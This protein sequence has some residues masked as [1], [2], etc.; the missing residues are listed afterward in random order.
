MKTL[1]SLIKVIENPLEIYKYDKVILNDSMLNKEG[2][3]YLY[4]NNNLYLYLKKIFTKYNKQYLNSFKYFIKICENIEFQFKNALDYTIIF[5]ITSIL[6]NYNIDYNKNYKK[7]LIYVINK[8]KFLE[9]YTLFGFNII[10]EV[11]PVI[12]NNYS[13]LNYRLYKYYKLYH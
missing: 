10:R 5:F 8:C 1:I 6:S 9:I 2:Y 4:C 11:N 7:I 13:K 12:N 3:N